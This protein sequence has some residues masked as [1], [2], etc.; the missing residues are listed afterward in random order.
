MSL[1]TS[2]PQPP[3]EPEAVAARLECGDNEVD[4]AARL[5]RF[6]LP[7]VQ[8][9][10]QRLRIGAEF[11]QWLAAEARDKTRRQPSSKTE[12]ND[13]SQQLMPAHSV[14]PQN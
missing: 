2:R 7:T 12:F 13:G 8:E 5:G 6:G 11:L 1:D 4:C 14:G 3:R 9:L 10:Q